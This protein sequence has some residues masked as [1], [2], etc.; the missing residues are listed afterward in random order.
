MVSISK[1]ISD[2]KCLISD[3]ENTLGSKI[4]K[5]IKSKS[6]PLSHPRENLFL[7]IETEKGSRLSKYNFPAVEYLEFCAVVN[8]F[9]KSSEISSLYSELKNPSGYFNVFYELLVYVF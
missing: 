8:D 7:L 5:S 4:V 9:S 1:N 2:I 6:H 3:V